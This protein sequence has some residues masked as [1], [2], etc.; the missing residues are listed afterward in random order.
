MKRRVD[1]RKH[2]RES[3]KL[4]TDMGTVIENGLGAAYRLHFLWKL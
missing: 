4:R 1:D 3:D 2:Y